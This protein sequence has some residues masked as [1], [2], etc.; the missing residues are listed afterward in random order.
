MKHLLAFSMA[1]LLLLSSGCA[2]VQPPEQMSPTKLAVWANN[3]YVESYNA[4]IQDTKNPV[5][6]TED[7]KELLRTKKVILIE[8]R[9]ALDVLNQYLDSGT[10]PRQQVTDMVIQIAYK[11]LEAT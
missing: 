10:L 7:Q 5:M 8:M 11:L 6:L 4:Y 1:L 2:T 3:I 9:S